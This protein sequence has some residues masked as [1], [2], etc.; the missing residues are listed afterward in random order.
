MHFMASKNLYIYSDVYFLLF[1]WDHLYIYIY[2]Y[3][4]RRIMMSVSEEFV[5]IQLSKMSWLCHMTEMI[6]NKWQITHTR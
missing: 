1:I 4:I 6:K 2:R 5:I 3:D